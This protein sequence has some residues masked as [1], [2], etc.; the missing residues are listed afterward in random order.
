MPQFIYL[1]YIVR[2]FKYYLQLSE[3]AEDDGGVTSR[4][5][6]AHRVGG[7]LSVDRLMYEAICVLGKGLGDN[8]D[9]NISTNDSEGDVSEEEEEKEEGTKV[10]SSAP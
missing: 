2:N 8:D 5:G 4:L 6:Q 10:H 7:D 1:Y 9:N 3:T